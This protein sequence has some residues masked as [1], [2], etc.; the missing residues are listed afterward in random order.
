MPQRPPHDHDEP[1]QHAMI[2]AVAVLRPS[3]QPRLRMTA[4][5]LTVYANTV[6]PDNPGCRTRNFDPAGVEQLIQGLPRGH[7]A[8]DGAS[9]DLP[10]NNCS[11]VGGSTDLS[12][13]IKTRLPYGSAVLDRH[14]AVEVGDGDVHARCHEAYIRGIL[15]GEG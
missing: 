7:L 14:P 5:V 2:T 9:R 10:R 15:G 13:A 6:G 12:P 4:G 8:R 3:P 1:A 11:G